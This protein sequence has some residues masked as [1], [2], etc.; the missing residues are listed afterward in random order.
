MTMVEPLEKTPSRL[1][2]YKDPNL[3]ELEFVDGKTTWSRSTPADGELLKQEFANI[4]DNLKRQVEHLNLVVKHLLD[5]NVGQIAAFMMY[6][7]VPDNWIICDGRVLLKS[8]F[9]GLHSALRGITW[10]DATLFRIPDFRGYFLRGNNQL[11]DR[12]PDFGRAIREIQKD[13]VAEHTHTFSATT[14]SAAS[15]PDT[16]ILRNVPVPAAHGLRDSENRH[17]PQY[18]YGPLGA[19]GSNRFSVSYRDYSQ[20]NTT[21]TH[22][23]S[24]TTQRPSQVSHPFA[25]ETRPINKSVI[26]CIRVDSSV[27]VR[28]GGGWVDEI[29]PKEGSKDNFSK[30]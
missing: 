12:N 29:E 2:V 6:E 4:Y 25:K 7:R 14:S 17:D 3:P 20:G 30:N 22:S 10:N 18:K 5:E 11:T 19:Y 16:L 9:P 15:T 28:G 27:G 23:V 24:G 1:S 21:H 8:R 13:G 26:Y